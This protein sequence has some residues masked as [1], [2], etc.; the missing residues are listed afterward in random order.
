MQVRRLPVWARRPAWPT[1]PTRAGQS[2]SRQPRPPARSRPEGG[3][4]GH[5]LDEL[6]GLLGPGAVS[7]VMEDLEAHSCDVW[8][9]VTNQLSLSWPGSWNV[10]DARDRPWP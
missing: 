8:P 1:E 2:G 4:I 10:P 3:R 6:T 7:T 5:N 9:L